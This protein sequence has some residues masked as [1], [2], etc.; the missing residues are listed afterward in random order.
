MRNL[1]MSAI[2]AMVVGLVACA[3]APKSAGGKQD[4]EARAAQ[5]LRDM[6]QRDPALSGLLRSSAGFAVFP[7]VGKGGFVVGGAFGQG[8]LYE[9]GRPT[10]YVSISE[11]SIGL[12]AG[13]QSYAEL[14]VFK[15]RFNVEKLKGGDFSL[16]A[17]ASAVA[18]KSGAAA[19]ADFKD[20]TAVFVMPRGGLMAEA[21]VGGQQIN[22]QPRG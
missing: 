16:G 17:N 15:D 9:Q 11:G 19:G 13:G 6:Q 18:L 20:G 10:G 1:R 14:I 12:Q 22:F 21:S 5:T 2:V 7:D 8:V 4:L 3:T